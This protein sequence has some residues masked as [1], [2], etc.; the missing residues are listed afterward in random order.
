MR[1]AKQRPDPPL[2]LASMLDP[3]VLADPYP[4]YHRLRSESPVHWDPLLRVWVVTHLWFLRQ[5]RS[6]CATRARANT[7]RG[8]RG[9]ILSWAAN[10]SRSAR[11]CSP[12]WEQPTA[13]R[14]DSP[15]PTDW[16]LRDR[17]IATW[18]LGGEAISVSAPRWPV[19]RLRSL[20]KNCSVFKTGRSNQGRPWCGVPTWPCAA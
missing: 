11:P 20:S 16:M 3:E 2:S 18:L 15:S 9:K 4:L 19:S 5:S 17:I 8:S 10:A 1:P 13:T 7:P 12:S 14:N 6:C